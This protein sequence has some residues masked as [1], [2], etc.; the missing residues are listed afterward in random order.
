MKITLPAIDLNRKWRVAA[1]GYL[2]FCI[3][4]TIA[5]ATPLREAKVLNPSGVDNL[6]PLIPST[7]WIYM[8]QFFFLLFS[9]AILKKT[10]AISRALYA[11][12]VA[13]AL[14]FVVFFVYPTTITREPLMVEGLTGAL[15][16]FLYRIDSNANCFPSLHVSLAWI[17]AMGVY[18]ESRKTGLV[19]FLIAVMISLSTLTTKQHYFIDII[20]GLAVAALCYIVLSKIDLKAQAPARRS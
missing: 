14:S 6:I 16:G 18:E 3:V 20:S 11:M 9:V 15:F 5:G 12:A 1:I 10:P 8:A 17:A 19:A 13:S 2:V 4:Y 7:V